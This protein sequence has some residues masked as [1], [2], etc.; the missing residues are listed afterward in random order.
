MLR[1]GGCFIHIVDFSDHFS[2]SDKS[3]SSANFLRYN[4]EEWNKLAGN[5]F[6]YQ[7]RLRIDDYIKLFTDANMDV[8]ANNVVID[9]RALDCIRNGFVI[10]QQFR[11]KEENS[12]AASEAMFTAQL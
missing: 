9:K 5:Q 2:H 11:H 4:N 8:Y 1:H 7:N 6:M 3:I 12:L 10:D